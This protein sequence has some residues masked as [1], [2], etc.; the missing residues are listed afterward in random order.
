MIQKI[1]DTG[2][3]TSG[4]EVTALLARQAGSSSKEE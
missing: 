3:K 1:Y 2:E 4:T